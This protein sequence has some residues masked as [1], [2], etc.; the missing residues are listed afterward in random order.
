[1]RPVSRQS[2]DSTQSNG[3]HPSQLPA[4]NPDGSYSMASQ[5]PSAVWQQHQDTMAQNALGQGPQMHR[6]PFIPDAAL[7]QPPMSFSPN[8]SFQTGH[9]MSID[10]SGQFDGSFDVSM[11]AGM[12]D[13][14]AGDGNK[15]KKGSSS[16]QANDVELRRLFRE[17]KQKSLQ[18]VAAQVMKDEKGPKSEKS[19]Q[20]FGMIW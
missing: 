14:N 5:M 13:E 6:H 10:M 8:D 4:A 2:T 17:N 12:Q 19:K 1:M 9:G 16:S 15:R 20:I 11:D 18:E 3:P 7:Q